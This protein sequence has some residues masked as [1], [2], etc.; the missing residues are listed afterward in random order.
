[1]HEFGQRAERLGDLL[2]V[3]VARDL[4]DVVVRGLARLE[5]V[6]D[7]IGGLGVFLVVAIRGGG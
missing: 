3:R 5:L 7:G 6:R 4:Q 2:L 1:M